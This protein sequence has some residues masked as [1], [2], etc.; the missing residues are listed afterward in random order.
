[1]SH[2]PNE[3][4]QGGVGGGAKGGAEWG[5]GADRRDGERE[6][7]GGGREARGG[8]GVRIVWS[9]AVAMVVARQRREG[10]RDEGRRDAATAG[11]VPAA[12]ASSAV[13]EPDRQRGRRRELE[14]VR[15]W[16][17]K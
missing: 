3:P 15:P 6:A 11:A 2:A 5:G 4:S 14:A 8:G 17:M 7:R 13:G 9:R 16:G 12:G 1:M 10:R